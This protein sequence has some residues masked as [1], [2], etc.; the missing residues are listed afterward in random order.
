MLSAGLEIFNFSQ[1]S[2]LTPQHEFPFPAWVDH[3]TFDQILSH[4]D[5]N[6]KFYKII[7]TLLQNVKEQ[8]SGGNW[9]GSLFKRNFKFEKVDVTGLF[10]LLIYVVY[11]IISFLDCYHYISLCCMKKVFLYRTVEQTMASDG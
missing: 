5:S 1:T 9:C 4:S 7:S 2:T 8:E 10:R 3:F 6:F 11:Y